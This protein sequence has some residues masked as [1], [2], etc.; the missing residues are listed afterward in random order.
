MMTPTNK[1]LARLREALTAAQAAF[2]NGN[3]EPFKALWSHGDDVTI[4]GAF[5]GYEQG[6]DLVGP[7]LDWA[8]SQFRDGACSTT[9]LSAHITEHLACI[10]DIERTEARLGGQSGEA[11]PGAAGNPG[12][13]KRR[14][15]LPHYSSAC[16]PSSPHCA[17]RQLTTD[18]KSLALL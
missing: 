13:S 5:G 1:A 6:W 4:L 14:R 8:S 3:P 17:T 2:V 10:V 7:R 15:R 12:L 18:D 11:H 9:P 16:G